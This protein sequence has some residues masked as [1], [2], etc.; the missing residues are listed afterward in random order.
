MSKVFFNE[1][2]IPKLNINLE[3][4]SGSHAQQTAKIISSFEPILE[5]EK[6]NVVL[7]VGDVNLTLAC[8]LVASKMGIKI[9][10]VEA[11]LRSF[12]WVMP[13][14]INSVI[15]DGLPDYLFTTSKDANLNLEKEGGRNTK[16]KETGSSTISSL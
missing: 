15:T 1:L 3:V 4:D 12:N 9:A 5:K 16:I 14:E 8:S 6:P 13:E 10:Y 11:G 7:L 2:E